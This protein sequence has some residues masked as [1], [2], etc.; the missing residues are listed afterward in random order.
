MFLEL[1]LSDGFS[2]LDSGMHFGRTSSI[3]MTLC[4][5]NTLHQEAH[6]VFSCNVKFEHLVQ[7]Q[8]VSS[9]FLHYKIT[10]IFFLL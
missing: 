2:L 3:G 1:D 10:T 5:L 6:G 4:L 8:V 7:V 9:R